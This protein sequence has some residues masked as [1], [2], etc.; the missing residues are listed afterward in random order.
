[1]TPRRTPS[2]PPTSPRRPLPPGH[3]LALPPSFS[4]STASFPSGVPSTSSHVSNGL[5]PN[6]ASLA[7]ADFEVDVRTGF[8]PGK[9][10]IER[11][12]G[13]WTVWEEALD[14]ARGTAPGQGLRIGGGR[15][16]DELWR[17]GIEMMPIVDTAGLCVSLPLLRRAHVVL[18]FLAHFYAHTTAPT[19]AP[20]NHPI[21]IPPSISIPLLTISPLLGLP[22]VATYADT[23]LYNVLPLDPSRELSLPSN[24]P[25][26][27]LASFTGTRSEEHFY[28]ISAI[29]E[30]AGAEAL[31]LMRQSL[32]ELFLAD[33]VAIRRLTIYLRKLAT[34]IDRIADITMTMLKEVDPEDFYHLIR[35]WF[36]GGDADGPESAGWIYQGLD[37]QAASSAENPVERAENKGRMFSGPSAG[38]SSLIHAIDI[39]LTVDHSP[40]P[41]EDETSLK[42]DH[43][44]VTSPSATPSPSRSNEA[45][46]VQRM[47]QYMPLPHRTFLLHLSTHPT[48]L[49]QLVVHSAQSH[50]QLA[51]AY[52]TALEALKRFRER[53]FRIV[54]VFIVQ[55]ARRQPSL[56]V[57]RLLGTAGEDE[58]IEQQE[59]AESAV[60][61]GEIRGTGG[62]PLFKF[63]RRCR[64]N[65]TKAMIGKPVGPHF[66]LQ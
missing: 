55:Q 61:L 3:F 27:C 17:Q 33:E 28:V 49:R 62:T 44:P 2:P 37:E 65:T 53:H 4:Q 63:L 66:D 32:D 12:G 18:V 16:Q 29:C 60:A 56:R 35:P 34:Q 50:P 10:N 7:S 31:R 13:E 52:D 26:T 58:E 39:F 45:T 57:R 51:E 24:P 8:L 9:N 25:A 42:L 59:E 19:P 21:N 14:A 48:P 40:T 6:V 46:F 36:R 47:L 15:Q 11:L 1:M 20:R 5:A 30:I 54:S 64:D 38:Q 43:E 22:P 23:V 41:E